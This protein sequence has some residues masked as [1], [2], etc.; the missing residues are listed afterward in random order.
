MCPRPFHRFID[1]VI[2]MNKRK[3]VLLRADG[4]KQIGLGHLNRVSLIADMLCRRFGFEAK[5]LFRSNDEAGK[6]LSNHGLAAESLHAQLTVDSEID[7]LNQVIRH[8]DPALVVFDLLALEDENDYLERINHDGIP[9]I[10]ITDDSKRRELSADIVLNG[11]PNQ[12]GQDYGLDS[13]RYLLGPNYFIMDP[14]IRLAM[15]KRP[16]GQVRDILLTFGGSDHNDLIFKVMNVVESVPQLS[17]LRLKLVV[18]SACGY[19][20]RLL[21]R[22]KMS[23]LDV[24][25][26]I[27]ADGLAALWAQVDLAVT[28]GGNTLFE[29]IASRLP[30]ATVCQLQRQMEIADKFAELGVNVNLG[31]GPELSELELADR[32][33]AFIF[34]KDNHAQ[35]YDRAPEIIDGRGLDRLGDAIEKML[36]RGG[37]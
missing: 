16:D 22:L 24:E 31:Y 37:R 8:D 26:I 13:Y 21:D 5:V 18:S 35:Q 17:G 10:A 4:N 15:V 7:T 3:V 30:G 1:K 2:R 20:E 34:D 12:H 27:D 36:E 25:L 6:F 14:R 9:F 11:N 33:A 28:A 23:A 29:R 19:I 32:L